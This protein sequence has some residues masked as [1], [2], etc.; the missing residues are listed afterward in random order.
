M[1]RNIETIRH[2]N[3]KTKI[4]FRQIPVLHIQHL[5]RV[6]CCD[7]S[8]TP[9]C[10]NDGNAAPMAI[11]ALSASQ[12]VNAAF[13]SQRD[14]FAAFASFAALATSQIGLPVCCI[15]GI[16]DLRTAHAAFAT[17]S[18]GGYGLRGCRLLIQKTK[19]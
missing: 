19:E 2:R 5:A 3:I 13:A 1:A 10:C 9:H 8:M 4:M 6:N 14:C 18:L 12:I 15:C 17:L 7:F 16:P 11:A